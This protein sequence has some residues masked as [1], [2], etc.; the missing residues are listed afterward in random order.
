MHSPND[1][2]PTQTHTR[3]LAGPRAV[4]TLLLT[5]LTLWGGV[6]VI[7]GEDGGDT[8]LYVAGVLWVFF[9][10]L[11]LVVRTVT[12]FPDSAAH[13]LQNVGLVPATSG[14]A[15]IEAM[16]AR[17]RH[18]EAADEGKDLWIGRTLADL[19]DGPLQAPGRAMVELGGMLEALREERF[20]VSMEPPSPT[21][22][23]PV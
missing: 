22:D 13:F 18:A 3:L 20:E 8:L 23:S 9:G 6:L 19:Y 7:Q 17:G 12:T 2:G 4:P 14:L 15:A 1:A 16:A 5:G 21:T 11:T 10:L